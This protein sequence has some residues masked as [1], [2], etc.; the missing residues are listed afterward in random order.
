MKKSFNQKTKL[1]PKESSGTSEK[2]RS[3][4]LSPQGSSRLRSPC[5][6]PH[7][8]QDIPDDSSA[9]ELKIASLVSDLQRTRADFEN[10]RKQ[11]EIQR[12][13]AK[14]VAVN[15]TV[16]KLLPLLDDIDRAILAYPEQ[17]G[18]LTKTL[19]KTL[20]ELGLMKIDSGPGVEFNPDYHDAISMDD[21]EGAREVI[22]ETLRSGYTYGGEVVRPAMVRVTHRD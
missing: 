17:L 4:P 7:T 13:Q 15:A 8:S 18:A 16:L 21:T 19:E 2:T 11:V 14:T 1:D 5:Q 10:Y 22:A 9:D 6:V 20:K 12:E 3:R